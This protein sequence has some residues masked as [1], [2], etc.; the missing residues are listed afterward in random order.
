MTDDLHSLTG[1]YA[2][3]AVD[4]LERARFEAHL[5][6]CADC[7]EEVE[8][9]RDLSGSLGA[10]YD[11]APPLALRATLLREIKTVRPL[12]PVVE[13][14]VPRHARSQSRFS[15]PVRWLTSV[16]AAVLVAGGI[17]LHPWSPTTT[18][19]TQISATGQVLTASDAQVVTRTLKQGGTVTITRSAKLGKAVAVASNLR[20]VGAGKAY[21]LWILD[22]RGNA[23]PAGLLPPGDQQQVT[24]ILTAD[25]SIA[26]GAAITIEPSGGSTTPTMPLAAK[27]TFKA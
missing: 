1:A 25:A 18:T 8:S 9:M 22:S 23:T 13:A 17:A 16:A 11:V 19:P 5:R 12:P 26:S 2:L 27:Y 15:T 10:E 24:Q 3:D 20:S 14:A 7:R 6:E 21:E 4:D